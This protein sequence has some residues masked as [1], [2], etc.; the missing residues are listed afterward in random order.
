MSGESISFAISAIDAEPESDGLWRVT[1][2][3]SNTGDP[4]RVRQSWVPHGEFFSERIQ[5]DPPLEWSD[6]I[7]VTHEVEWSGQDV[8]N[9][10]LI[11]ELDTT[12][13]FF[14]IRPGPD[15][16][17]VEKVTIQS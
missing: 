8:A 7:E 17:V 1:F 16:I 4:V 13:V 3:L 9:A 2:H 15:A 14:R 11:L 6:A 12:R 10:F 5:Y